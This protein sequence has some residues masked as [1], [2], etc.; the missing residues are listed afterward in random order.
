MEDG[1]TFFAIPPPTERWDLC[2]LWPLGYGRSD[3]ML[4]LGLAVNR[5]GSPALVCWYAQP[6]RKDRAH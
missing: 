6:P 2:P 5:T 1:S 3:T 4:V